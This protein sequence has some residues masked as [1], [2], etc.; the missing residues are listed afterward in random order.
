M[1]RI[2]TLAGKGKKTAQYIKALTA[3][4]F[5]SFQI[6]FWQTLDGVDLRQ[7]ADEI[8]PLLEKTGT[9]VSSLG[10]F[11]NPLGAEEADLETVRVWKEAIERAPDF[12]CNLV[13]GFAGRVRGKPVPDSLPRLKEV[14][15]PLLER[16]QILGVRVAFE[17]CPM[18][19]DWKTGDWNIAFNPDAWELIFDALSSPN[20]GLEWE[21][22]HQLTQLIDP[23][24][25]LRQWVSKVFHVHG[26]DASVY[27]DIIAARGIAGTK[28]FA[29]H[30]HPGFGDTNWTDVISILRAA[31]YRGT[32]DI[33]GWHDPVYKDDL[34]MTGQV[35]A[36][37]YL[38]HCRG[39][40]FVSNPEI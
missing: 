31:D 8:K 40:A 37:R 5:E 24:P 2:G 10:A 13:C 28:N 32:I 1:I 34:E 21:P 11:G 19:G 27:R 4:G 35:H 30:R 6:N 26:K 22:C 15:L 16:A 39:G 20:V 23:I 36:L 38:Q 14:W 33:E 29:E 3:L 18:G 12:G 17:N 7:L 25:Q 9:I